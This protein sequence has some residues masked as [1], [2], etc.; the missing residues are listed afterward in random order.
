MSEEANISKPEP[1]LIKKGNSILSM[2]MLNSNIG[3]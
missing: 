3:G 2:K 1:K